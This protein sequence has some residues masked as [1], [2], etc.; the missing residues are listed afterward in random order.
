MHLL[1]TGPND[2]APLMNPGGLV[3]ST[4]PVDKQS[5]SYSVCWNAFKRLAKAKGLD[6]Q[7]K[8]ALYG[9]TA[10]RVYRLEPRGGG[11]RL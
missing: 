8:A 10:T 1:L 2:R 5:F 4:V 3:L 9:G 7:A 11:G 6:E